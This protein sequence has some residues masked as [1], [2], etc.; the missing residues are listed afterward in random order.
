MIGPSCE[1]LE[2]K[3]SMAFLTLCILHQFLSKYK[4]SWPLL[5][6]AHINLCFWV[7]FLGY[8]TSPWQMAGF[9]HQLLKKSWQ[10]NIPNIYNV[11]PMGGGLW[12]WR[13]FGRWLK[14]NLQISAPRGGSSVRGPL[15][16]P[17]LFFLINCCSR[18]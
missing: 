16:A 18:L 3:S 14:V 2:E 12:L 7:W 4:N 6:F 17:V 13:G 9:Q 11:N 1:E 5:K 15:L 10:A 8:M